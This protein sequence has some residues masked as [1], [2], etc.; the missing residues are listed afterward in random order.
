MIRAE[1]HPSPWWHPSINKITTR[2][3]VFTP[4]LEFDYVD[5][6]IVQK[7]QNI[8]NPQSLTPKGFTTNLEHLNKGSLTQK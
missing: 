7:K 4:F 2:Q 3:G 5:D 6:E 8:F 1:W